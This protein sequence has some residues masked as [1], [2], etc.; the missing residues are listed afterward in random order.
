MVG[1]SIL[2]HIYE[3]QYDGQCGSVAHGRNRKFCLYAARTPRRRSYGPLSNNNKNTETRNSPP[4][5]RL[6]AARKKVQALQATAA[7][8]RLNMFRGPP[9]EGTPF[10]RPGDALPGR[11]WKKLMSLFE[12]L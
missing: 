12:G 8:D 1:L 5:A 2:K 9:F 7:D 3:L 11:C 10:N 4:V 6:V